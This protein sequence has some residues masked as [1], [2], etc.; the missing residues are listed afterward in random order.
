MQTGTNINTP[1][2][3]LKFELPKKTSR[4]VKIEM[5]DE[6]KSSIWLRIIEI[7]AGLI[8]LVLAGY[9]IAYPGAD[10]TNTYSIPS[11]RSDYPRNSYRSCESLQ[12][13]FPDG[14]DY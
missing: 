13:A 10:G 11:D 2:H 8:I 7:I 4:E 1:T 12:E 14:N 5:A 3:K 6:K 9:V